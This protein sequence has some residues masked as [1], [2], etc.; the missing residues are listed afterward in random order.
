MAFEKRLQ[1]VFAHLHSVLQSL[2][3]YSGKISADVFKGQVLA[4]LEVWE[5]WY[6]IQVID[7]LWLTR[8][9]RIYARR[10]QYPARSI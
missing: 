7:A 9:D 1:P 3:A 6:V 10:Q 8:Q 2:D 5:R 4:I